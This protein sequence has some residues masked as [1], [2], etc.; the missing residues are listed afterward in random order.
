MK[1]LKL[2][3]NNLSDK[4][5]SK[6]RDIFTEVNGN[7][8]ETIDISD[9]NIYEPGGICIAEIVKKNPSTLRILDVSWNL[10]SKKAPIDWQ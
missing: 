10:F 8:L 3:K 9:N 2:A 4:V 7:V 5:A 1:T 6:L